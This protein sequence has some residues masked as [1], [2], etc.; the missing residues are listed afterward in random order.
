[1]IHC[2]CALNSEARPLLQHFGLKQDTQA[3]RFKLYRNT[4]R[5]VT[6]TVSGAGKLAAAAAVMH[7]AERLRAVPSQGWI[8]FGI[9][10]HGRFALGQALLA[11]RVEDAGSG[12]VWFPCVLFDSAVPAASVL[13]LDRPSADYG[14][15]LFDLEAAGYYASVCRIT[16]VEMA[17][18]VKIVSD[19]P[20]HPLRPLADAF[21]SELIAE[22]LAHIDNLAGQLRALGADAAEGEQP[23]PHFAAIQKRWRFTEYQR[24]TLNRLLTRW[25]VLLPDRNPLDAPAQ[26]LANAAALL[27]HLKSSLDQAPSGLG[28]R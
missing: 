18:C 8:N 19:N 1:M 5:G 10:G 26:A 13:T 7:T 12:Q 25:Q 17:H 3:S 2:V 23:P 4:E 21:V 27:G 11:N 22:N 15:S 24:A 9:A 28:R 14:E 16:T 20:G 6:L